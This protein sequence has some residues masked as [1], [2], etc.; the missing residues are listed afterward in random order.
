MSLSGIFNAQSGTPF[1]VYDCTKSASATCIRAIG[2][3]AT[4]G[5]G[6]PAERDTPNRFE[7]IDLRGLKAGSYVNAITGT[8]IYGPFPADMTA[9]NAF[10]GPGAW[11]FDAALFKTF[12]VREWVTPQLR[13]EVYNV[14]NHANLFIVGNETDISRYGYAPARRDGRRNIQFALRIIF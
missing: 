11:N 2:S 3:A 9:R 1:S 8:S 6:N 7:Y 4:S 14:F 5:S 12:S 10:R 13:A